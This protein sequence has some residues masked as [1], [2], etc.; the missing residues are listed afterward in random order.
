MKAQPFTQFIVSLSI[1]V[2]F[3]LGAAAQDSP[4]KVLGD[5]LKKDEVAKGAV[6]V[7]VP[8]EEIQP[9]IEKVKAAS[10]ANQDWFVEYSAKATP[11]VPLPF[12]ENLGLSKEE[13]AKYLE[14]WDQRDFK[15]VQEVAIRLEKLGDQW[16]IRVG[17][18]GAKIA[19]LRYNEQTDSFK[20][21]NG[22]MKRIEDIKADPASIM[23]G[24]TG[25]EWKFEETGALGTTKENFA[26]G[27]TEDQ[28]HGLLIYRLQDVSKDGR[29]LYD[30]S[31]LIRFALPA[32]AGPFKK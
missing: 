17:G 30:Q 2:G 5:Y 15:T 4:P 10:V 29:P 9:Y 26:I 28:K 7:V 31:V 23:R 1:W 20:S 3:T 22:A 6:V 27:K 11:G 13:Y 32:V 18:V 16:M 21:P 25:H 19:L 8:P 24:W 12:H 14:L